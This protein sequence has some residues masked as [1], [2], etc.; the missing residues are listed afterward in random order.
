MGNS[1]FILD[2]FGEE[3][4]GLC[5]TINRKMHVRTSV[6]RVQTSSVLCGLFESNVVFIYELFRVGSYKR[7]YLNGLVAM[8]QCVNVSWKPFKRTLETFLALYPDSA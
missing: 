2:H 6:Q 1:S 7:R 8:H 3:K 5:W 4:N